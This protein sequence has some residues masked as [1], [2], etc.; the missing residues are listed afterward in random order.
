MHFSDAWL[1]MHTYHVHEHAELLLIAVIV[2][3]WGTKLECI[4]YSIYMVTPMIQ[5][6]IQCH[7]SI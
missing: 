2:Q 3:P 1:P 4:Q 5:V 7:I 6:A